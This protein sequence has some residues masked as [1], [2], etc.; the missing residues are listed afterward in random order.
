MDEAK[1]IFDEIDA[2]E[3]EKIQEDRRMKDFIVDDDGFGYKDHGGEIWDASDVK[4]NGAKKKKMKVLDVRLLLS[5]IIVIALRA[6][7]HKLYG[8]SVDHPEEKEH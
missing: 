4:E 8:A 1:K 5:L 3:Y 2:D 6:G 7:N